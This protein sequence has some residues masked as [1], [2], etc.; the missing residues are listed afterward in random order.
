MLKL[1]VGATYFLTRKLAGVSAEMSLNVLVYN[2]KRFMKI[3]GTHHLMT[4][5]TA[6][7]PA[8]FLLTPMIWSVAGPV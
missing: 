4:A 8:C 2:L 5:L 1:W 7:K 6:Y 3:F